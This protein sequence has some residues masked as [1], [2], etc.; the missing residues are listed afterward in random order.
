MPNSANTRQN[1]NKDAVKTTRTVSSYGDNSNMY[2][3]SEE[4]YSNGNQILNT[5]NV[6]KRV[7]QTDNVSANRGNNI[8]DT[9][10]NDSVYTNELNEG[11]YG[12]RMR[13]IGNPDVVNK[14]LH[15]DADKLKAD[16]VAARSGFNDDRNDSDWNVLD[17][18]TSMP[19]KIFSAITCV[20]DDVA[21]GDDMPLPTSGNNLFLAMAT[22]VATEV[23]NYKK[24]FAKISASS[25]MKKADLAVKN[26]VEKKAKQI[27]MIQKLPE[28]PSKEK[29][30]K[31]AQEGNLKALMSNP[32]NESK[33]K[34]ST[35]DKDEYEAKAAELVPQL[36]EL[37]KQ[38]C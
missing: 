20:D 2:N 12:S 22:D 5:D 17:S 21:E 7:V 10:G 11:A 4:V 3:S 9:N 24:K 15:K 26:E 33:V 19:S 1:Y 28:S 27:E 38:C 14:E 16:I 37:E 36:I 32:S 13:I 8:S 34:K 23:G 6:T 18:L 31:A 25:Q 35:Y 30:L 29:L